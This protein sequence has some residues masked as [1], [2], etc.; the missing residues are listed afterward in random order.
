VRALAALLRGDGRQR[1]PILL[2]IDSTMMSPI[3]Q[4]PIALGADMVAFA[5]PLLGPATRSPAATEA[6]LRQILLELRTAMFLLGVP[7]IPT[8][9]R[10][11]HLLQRITP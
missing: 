4:R 10:S 5:M 7:D 2:S 8:L 9:R 1:A 3:L 6:A 11:R